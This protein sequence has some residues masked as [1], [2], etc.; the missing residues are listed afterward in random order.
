M[1]G[2]KRR[3]VLSLARNKQV[4]ELAMYLFSSSSKI[5]IFELLWYKLTF[6]FSG[7]LIHLGLTEVRS[8]IK[9]RAQHE[10]YTRAGYKPA[11]LLESSERLRERC[12][13][14]KLQEP[15]LAVPNY[16]SYPPLNFC[17]ANVYPTSSALLLSVCFLS[18]AVI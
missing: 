13:Q 2:G 12:A 7:G 6:I 18:L 3:R 1:R 5:F 16:F 9:A 11:T 15:H 17:V 14:K 8:H 10:G 4:W